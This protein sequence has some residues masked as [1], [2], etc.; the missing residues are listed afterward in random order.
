MNFSSFLHLAFS[1]L[2]VSYC[3][4][5]SYFWSGQFLVSWPPTYYFFSSYIHTVFTV[6]LASN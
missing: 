1:Q 3:S 4:T 2:L 5:R 6:F